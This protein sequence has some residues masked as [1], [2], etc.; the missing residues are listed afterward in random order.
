MLVDEMHHE[1]PELIKDQFW[2][3]VF[4]VEVPYTADTEKYRE[5]APEPSTAKIKVPMHDAEHLTKVKV[6][7]KSV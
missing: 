5:E 4:P 3:E 7:G 6:N 2:D 1:H